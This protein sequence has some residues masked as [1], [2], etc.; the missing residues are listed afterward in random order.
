[1]GPA[2]GFIR[3]R[4]TAAECDRRLS[5]RGGLAMRGRIRFFHAEAGYGFIR[6]D[7]NATDIFFHLS[8][9]MAG[10]AKPR[11]RARCSFEIS[12]NTRSGKPMAIKVFVGGADSEP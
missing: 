10:G 11:K 7:D 2:E 4:H 3:S 6:A 8:S 5:V 1:M 12:D 9:V